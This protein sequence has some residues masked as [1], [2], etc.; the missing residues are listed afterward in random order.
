M[1][2][3]KAWRPV[4]RLADGTTVT[5]AH[6]ACGRCGGSG[7]YHVSLSGTGDGRDCYGCMGRGFTTTTTALKHWNALVMWMGANRPSAAE[8]VA[9][10]DSGRFGRV[11]AVT[12]P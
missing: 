3:A 10:M 7:L 1:K 4:V 2:N 12:R 9:A 5:V 8:V 6:K 11:W